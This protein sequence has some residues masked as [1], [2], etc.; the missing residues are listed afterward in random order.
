M[1]ILQKSIHING[2]C[3]R[4]FDTGEIEKLDN[5]TKEFTRRSGTPDSKGYRVV[6]IG[7]RVMKVH[8]IVAMA[9]LSDYS[10]SL[11]VDHKDGIKDNNRPENLRMA[12][13]QQNHRGMVRKGKGKSSK[14]R[15]VYWSKRDLRWVASIGVDGKSKHLGM[16]LRE[17]EAAL[18]YNDAATANR[19][20][21]EALNQV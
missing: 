1:N 6:K 5:R 13:N 16:F 19:F 8:R 4:V 7:S 9:F 11:Q 20:F 21:K 10:E 2:I 15:G 18:A 14:Y 17:L 12:T 3:V